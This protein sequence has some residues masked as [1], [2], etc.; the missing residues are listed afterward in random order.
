MDWL[1]DEIRGAGRDPGEVT[2][3]AVSKKR[4]LDEVRSV[5]HGGIEAVG[6]SRIDEAYDK[7]PLLSGIK[8]HMIGHLQR[9][10]VKDALELFDVI[11]SVDS[12][13]LAREID[14]KAR[15]KGIVAE[16]YFQINI[17]EEDSKYG[18]GLS[19]AQEFYSKLLSLTN[20]KVTGI[21]CIAPYLEPEGTR[22]YFRRMKELFDTLPVKN[23]SMGMSNDYRVALE[24]GSTEIRLGRKLFGERR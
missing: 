18:V 15:M 20:L 8:K 10:K 14:R 1:D 3:L 11:E 22:P 24:E 2:V 6:E 5:V 9:N 7:L 17:G 21:M 12:L 19:E 23:L 4:S 13:K 16:V